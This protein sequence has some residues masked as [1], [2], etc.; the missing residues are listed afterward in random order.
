[1]TAFSSRTAVGDVATAHPRTRRVFRQHG[2]PYA[3]NPKQAIRTAAA[4]RHIPVDLLLSDLS[5]A[6]REEETTERVL[7]TWY[8]ATPDELADYLE[9]MHH[10]LFRY[11]LEE[12]RHLLDEGAGTWGQHTTAAERV[13]E[14]LDRL[15]PHVAGHLET[16]EQE[17][18]PLT[19]QLVAWL[20]GCTADPR[21]PGWDVDASLANLA[22]DHIAI[23]R[24]LEQ[25]R[26]ATGHY[27]LE[28]GVADRVLS[29]YAV[30]QEFEDGLHRHLF[31]ENELLFPKLAEML[32]AKR[33]A[34]AV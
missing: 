6:A 3:C 16:E 19:R 8:G 22:A 33:P 1:M 25:M 4:E 5:L 29:L 32:A 26:Q 10:P 13:A 7:G 2:I 20:Q 11:R 23:G 34:A 24:M 18:F 30:L 17:L 27:H 15:Q 12:A 9:K 28:P 14:I 21:P 31:L